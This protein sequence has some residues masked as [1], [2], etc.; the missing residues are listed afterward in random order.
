MAT[1][2]RAVKTFAVAGHP[3]RY[4]WLAYLPTMPMEKPW[5]T[6]Y[7][8][9]VAELK[10]LAIFETWEH[11]RFK[12][13]VDLRQ[14]LPCYLFEGQP[15]LKDLTDEI[16]L[17]PEYGSA[18]EN[19]LRDLGL[20]A[21]NWEDII[22]RLRMDLV[23]TNSRIRSHGCDSPWFEAFAALCSLL[24]A[25]KH[26][27]QRTLLMK[28]PLIPLTNSN[29]WTGAPGMGGG[30][31][32][33]IYFPSTG[34]IPIPTDIGLALLKRTATT[35]TKVKDF[36]A[37]LGVECCPKATVLAKI[38]DVHLSRRKELNLE[39]HLRYLFYN[40]KRPCDITPWLLVPTD[41]G[42]RGSDWTFYFSSEVPYSTD[43]LLPRD[44]R[45]RY[46]MR[47]SIISTAMLN[48]ELANIQANNRTW[49]LWLQ[50]A[51]KA[52]DHPPLIRMTVW[53][54]ELS[55]DLSYVLEYN[56][57]SFL[58]TLKAHWTEYQRDALQ[59]KDVLKNTAVLCRST[60]TFPLQE[61]YLPTSE[62][63]ERLQELQVADVSLPIL[64]LPDVELDEV[65]CREW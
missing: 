51:T 40:H 18:Y 31:L 58:G 60:R 42:P 36:Y 24:L 14:L 5:K 12:R 32:A 54:I 7:T 27:A 41:S 52:R 23:N 19:A 61:T 64:R 16:Y 65:S 39:P 37:A 50:E 22:K 13:A 53:G 55:S 47:C 25:S 28:Q 35:K 4:S 29:Q 48:L 11:R 45:E 17:A 30:G 1:F 56:A 26:S 62:V 43:K 8:S 59:V 3:L 44:T 20:E 6:M 38:R 49:R 10:W 15:I 34:T 33:K 9:M 46:G 57:S 2:T 21:I 63:L